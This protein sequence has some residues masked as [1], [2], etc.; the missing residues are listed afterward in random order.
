[1]VGL[2][3]SARFS[4]VPNP[5]HVLTLQPFELHATHKQGDAPHYCLLRSFEWMI[6]GESTAVGAH[7]P[8]HHHCEW[9]AT[10]LMDPCYNRK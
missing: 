4:R 6:K 8:C 5:G 2:D 3:Y 10:N 9:N 7:E 1:M